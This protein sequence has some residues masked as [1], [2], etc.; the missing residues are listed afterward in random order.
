MTP[1]RWPRDD[2][3]TTRLLHV[4]PVRRTLRDGTIGDLVP[5]L[6][7]GDLLVLN[8]AAT[9]PA[10][11]HA[12]TES[13]ERLELRLAAREPDGA[14]RAVL[15]GAGDWRTRTE[16]RP[17]PPRLRVGDSLVV[18]RAR[19]DPAEISPAI[20]SLTAAPPLVATILGADRDSPRLVS[21]RF[22]RDG[23]ELWRALYAAGRPVQYAYLRDELS[24]W[25]VQTLVAARPW[26]V[27]PPSAGF[28]LTW[29][30]L[31]QVRRRGV[32][33]AR[34]THSA[35]LSSTGDAALDRRFPLAEHFD[36]PNE[37]VNAIERTHARGGRVVATGTTVTRAL[38][39]A[40]SL[41]DGRLVAGSGT[42]ELRLRAGIARAVVDGLVTGIHEPDTS[43][44]ALLESFADRALLERAHVFAEE[45]GYLGHEFGDAVVIL[46]ARER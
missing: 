4:D 33:L 3:R 36:V 43:H 7:R 45:H 6:E 10:S 26:A 1:A 2:P 39:G 18:G 27:E 40:A 12:T 25:H 15:F 23:A 11:L 9:I 13:G 37:T 14:W 19:N 28:P 5:L 30:L 31:L 38:E 24:L 8:D 16:D 35:G 44:F 20:V 29:E 34:V 41:H 22:D 46:G 17:A 42:T 32:E 21:L